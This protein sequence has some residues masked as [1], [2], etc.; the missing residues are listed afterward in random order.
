MGCRLWPSI[1]TQGGNL[2]CNLETTEGAAQMVLLVQQCFVNEGASV[3]SV[4]SG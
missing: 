2:G 4:K 3:R 1:L